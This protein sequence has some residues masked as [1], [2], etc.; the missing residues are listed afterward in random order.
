MNK[1]NIPALEEYL[2]LHGNDN[3]SRIRYYKHI[4]EV[5]DYEVI[6]AM[7]QGKTVSEE[8]KAYR[9]NAR[10]EINRIGGDSNE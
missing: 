3:E 7:E 5:T 10:D 2:A 9:Q 6:K 1:Y 4:L 8:L